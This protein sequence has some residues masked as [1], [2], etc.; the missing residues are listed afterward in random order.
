MES[1]RKKST[2]KVRKGKAPALVGI[3]MGSDSDL[4][5]MQ[6]AIDCLKEFGVSAEVKIVS[7]HRT[8]ESMIEYGIS[9]AER[10]L[11]VIIAGAGGAAHLP[12]MIASVTLLPV[13]GVPII[14]KATKL[15]GLDALLSIVQMP[16]GVPVA[17]VAIE[18]SFNAGLLAVRILAP[19][20]PVLTKKLVVFRQ[21]Q[22]D[23]VNRTN[24]SLK[25]K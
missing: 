22:V 11:R 24:R 1:S 16:K 23:K 6:G 17:T 8:P 18:G 5:K 21:A 7:A 19:H 20:D 25:K 13:I 2:S 15:D 10:G 3:I 4:A 12:G 14:A 9:A